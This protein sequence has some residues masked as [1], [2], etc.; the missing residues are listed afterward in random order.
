[1]AT[2]GADGLPSASFPGAIEICGRNYEIDLDLRNRIPR[3]DPVEIEIS[4][5]VAPSDTSGGARHGVLGV[6]SRAEFLPAGA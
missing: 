5:G 6:P 2:T 1:V 3:G 4:V